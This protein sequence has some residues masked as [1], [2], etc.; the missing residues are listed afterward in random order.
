M[1]FKY[2]V[3]PREVQPKMD[4]NFLGDSR[5]VQLKTE[6]ADSKN[7][8]SDFEKELLTDI[9]PEEFQEY[10]RNSTMM[11]LQCIGAFLDKLAD[12]G[13]SVAQWKKKLWCECLNEKRKQL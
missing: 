10:R 11:Q 4:F 13:H 9:D 8:L 2:L 6:N 12:A 5:E 3:N 7:N 1:G